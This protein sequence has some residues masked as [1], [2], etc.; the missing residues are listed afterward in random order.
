MFESLFLYCT[1]VADRL[2]AAA[3]RCA[4]R[5]RPIALSDRALHDIGVS[6]ADA[7]REYDKPFW[8]D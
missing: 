6:R 2:C 5:R 3:D 7:C 4:G 8:R 1:I